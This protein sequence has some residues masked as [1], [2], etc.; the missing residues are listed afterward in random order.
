MCSLVGRELDRIEHDHRTREGSSLARL[1]RFFARPANSWAGHARRLPRA[2]CEERQRPARLRSELGKQD[3]RMPEASS[4][5]AIHCSPAHSRGRLKGACACGLGI[6]G[7]LTWDSPARRKRL[8]ATVGNAIGRTS[9][10]PF[11]RNKLVALHWRV[12]VVLSRTSLQIGSGSGGSERLR[13]HHNH[14]AR[15]VPDLDLGGNPPRSKPRYRSDRFRDCLPLCCQ[16]R[17]NTMRS[18]LG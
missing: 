8:S 18:K 6:S 17:V 12:S 14:V 10:R 2:P 9:R 16:N 11:H 4:E 15:T 13:G 7:F 1:A 3:R 5:E